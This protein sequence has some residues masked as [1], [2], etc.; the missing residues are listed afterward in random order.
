MLGFT[1]YS[2]DSKINIEK[3]QILVS[4]KEFQNTV[5]IVFRFNSEL[6]LKVLVKNENEEVVLSQ[7]FDKVK[8]DSR[9]LDLSPL[10]SGNYI[11]TF[12]SEGK[13]LYSDKIKKI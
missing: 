6:N 10:E 11:I 4:P 1:T 3:D 5:G 12:I 9:K 8:I 13:V 7:D 2:Q